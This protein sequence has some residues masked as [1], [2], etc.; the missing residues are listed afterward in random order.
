MPSRRQEKVARVVKESVSDTITNRLSDPRIEGFIS[1]TEVDVSP[2][3]RNA[4][5]FLSIMAPN[6]T[7]RRKAFAAIEHATKYI[8]ARLSRRMTSKFCPHLHFHEDNKLKNTLETLRIID[9]AAK[10]LK[11]KDAQQLED[12]DLE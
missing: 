8:Q 11:E 7:A 12:S 3:L 6:D 5:V 9:E 1:V 10:E 2:D 4:E